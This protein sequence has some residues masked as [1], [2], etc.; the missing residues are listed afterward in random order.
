VKCSEVMAL[1]V[2]LAISKQQTEAEEA[3]AAEEKA[4][5]EAAEEQ[6]EADPPVA[7]HVFGVRWDQQWSTT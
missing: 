6:E 1:R 2:L 5:E 7:P 4:E 3:V